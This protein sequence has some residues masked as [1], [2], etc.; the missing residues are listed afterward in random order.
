MNT[1]NTDR[2]WPVSN[3]IKKSCLMNFAAKQEKL[4]GAEHGKRF[5]EMLKYIVSGEKPTTP[6]A[7]GI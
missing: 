5:S 1:K 7:E 6:N 2:M 3:S 4:L